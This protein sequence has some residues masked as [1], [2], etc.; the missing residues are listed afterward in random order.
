MPFTIPTYDE[1]LNAILTDYINQLPGGDTS[2]GSLIYIKSAAIA[3]ALWGLY[4]HQRWIADQI[5]PD[6]AATEALEHHAF[7]RGITRKANETDAELLARLLEYIRRPPAGGNRYDYV[8][9]A[10]EITN[11]KAAY[12]IPLGQGP[13][14]VDVVI[15]ANPSTGSEIPTQALI[16]EVWAYIDNLRPVT[17]KYLRVL[18]PTIL[19]Q[20]ITLSGAGASY[21]PAQTALDITAYLNGFTPGQTLYRSQLG[22]FAIVN[23]ADDVIVTIPALNVVSTSMQIIRPGVINVT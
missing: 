11:V 20:N 3:S 2:K 19:V 9:W 22:N 6:T 4:Q 13:G 23:G 14:S 18:P 16:D 12:C 10:M 17:A 7:I 8:K 5:F 1:L 15:V 21:N